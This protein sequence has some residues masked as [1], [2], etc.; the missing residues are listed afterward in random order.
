MTYAAE[1]WALKKEHRH[2]LAVAQRRMERAMVGVSLMDRRT[3]E[4]LRGVT[5]VNDV[6]VE[7]AKRKKAWVEKLA[8][9]ENERWAKTVFEWTPTPFHRHAG[10]RKRWRDE[11]VEVFGSMNKTLSLL[12]TDPST[13]TTGFSLHLQE[14]VKER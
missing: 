1:T 8:R 5:T 13:F 10:A 2:A 6:R 4:W 7:A 14:M 9:M 11:F 3:N 12:R